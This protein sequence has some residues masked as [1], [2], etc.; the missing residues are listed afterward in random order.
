MPAK[1]Y[2]PVNDLTMTLVA[3]GHLHTILLWPKL[4]KEWKPPVTL[5]WEGKP[6]LPE[7]K[8]SIPNKPGVYAFVVKPGVPLG[9]P[10]SVLMYIGMSNRPL[11]ERFQEYLR[12]MNNPTGRPAIHTILRMYDGYVH[13]Y[14]A[15]VEKPAKPKQI[16]D[17]LIATLVPP[18]NKQYP[19]KISRIV[20][21]FL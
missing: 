15:S 21:A 10:I 2:K 13:F 8:G 5:K 12:E 1:K 7:S 19:A 3:K 4:W 18:M 11:R 20:G 16:E 6:F 17:H 9:V 14:C